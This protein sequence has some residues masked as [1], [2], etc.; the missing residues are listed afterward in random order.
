MIFKGYLKLCVDRWLFNVL[1]F[2][3]NNARGSLNVVLKL[4][5]CSIL[6]FSYKLS[7]GSVLE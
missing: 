2:Q 4:A 6:P 7:Q 5:V 1:G 3:M